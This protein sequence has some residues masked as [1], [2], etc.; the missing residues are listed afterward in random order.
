MQ[1]N[2]HVND[3]ASAFMEIQN[4]YISE[5]KYLDSKMPVFEKGDLHVKIQRLTNEFLRL[6]F[7]KS[8][9]DSDLLLKISFMPH[10][11][12]FSYQEEGY[13]RLGL[14]PDRERNLLYRVDKLPIKKIEVCYITNDVMLKNEF[15]KAE[16]IANRFFEESNRSF[17]SNLKD[18]LGIKG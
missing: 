12:H 6:E 1:Y 7:N 8:F 14:K 4:L 3:L 5:T 13:L 15:A 9:N 11:Y 2:C 17:L 18:L 10:E 16:V